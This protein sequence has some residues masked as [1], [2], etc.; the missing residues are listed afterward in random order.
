MP[1]ARDYAE[2]YRQRLKATRTLLLQDELRLRHYDT[3]LVL[4]QQIGRGGEDGELAFF[5]GEVYRLRDD[6]GDGARAREAYAK[7][8][9]FGDC[10]PETHRALGLVEL[11]SGDRRAAEAAFQ[12]YLELRPNAA[13]R[14][15]IR[16]LM[17]ERA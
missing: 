9:G 12:R 6:T 13:D 8:L 1:D 10:P 4:L 14:E 11:K 16:S 15:M 5:T 17:R 7:A 3:T 2:R